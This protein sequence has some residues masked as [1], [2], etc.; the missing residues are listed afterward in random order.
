MTSYVLNPDR[1]EEA[2]ELW[3]EAAADASQLLDLEK[4]VQVTVS[5]V[6]NKRSLDQNN[7]FH[8]LCG[9]IAQQREW[10]GQWIDTEGWKRLLCDAWARESGRAQSRM[11]PSLDG[12]SVVNL[13]IQT[14]KLSKSEMGELLDWA[15]AWAINEGVRLP[16][17]KY[18]DAA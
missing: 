10:A 2:R 13:G 4:G 15:S 8:A 17:L 7:A 16:E 6:H 18:R 14:R 9:N 1:R 5:V 11:V 3:R 12:S